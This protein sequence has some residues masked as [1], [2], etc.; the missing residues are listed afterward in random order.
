MPTN[1]G[2]VLHPNHLKAVLIMIFVTSE[3]ISFELVILSYV[4]ISPLVWF[5]RA[6]NIGYREQ[7]MEF[8]IV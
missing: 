6:N 1:V 2:M 3:S 7:I 4:P 8:S 5:I